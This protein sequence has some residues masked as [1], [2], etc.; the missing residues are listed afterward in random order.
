MLK[1]RYLLLILLLPI[2]SACTAEH[3]VEQAVGYPYIS[4]FHPDKTFKA[5]CGGNQKPYTVEICGPK[6]QRRNRYILNHGTY[7][8][9]QTNCK[10]CGHC[11]RINN[12]FS[13]RKHIG[14]LCVKVTDL[15]ILPHIQFVVAMKSKPYW[16][17]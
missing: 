10:N 15:F 2:I 13:K 8:F 14:F 6:C 7:N 4:G 11:P 3:I 9:L 17:N 5:N 1:L 12:G 16:I